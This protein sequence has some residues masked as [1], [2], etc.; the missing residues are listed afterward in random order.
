V[1][2]DRATHAVLVRRLDTGEE[3]LETYDQLVL[4]PGAKAIVPDV[5][6]ADD[7]RVHVIRTVEDTLALR[8]CVERDQPQQAVVVGG[9]FIGLEAA[10]NLMGLGMQVTLLQRGSHVL[11]PLDD[12]MARLV[13]A[14][15]RDHGLDLR[16]GAQLEGF[17][18]DGRG[19]LLVRVAGDGPLSADLVVMAVG[20]SPDT[21][22]AQQAGLDMGVKGSIVVDAHMR[23]S[24]PDIHAVGDAVQ[25]CDRVTGEP[26][27]V[28]LAGPANKQGR[29]AADDIC[30]REGV[31]G[32]TQGSFVLKLF[33]LTVAGSGL[34]LAQARRAGFDAERVVTFSPSHAT[35][36]PGATDMTLKTVF[37]RATGRVLG[38]QAVGF[39][40]VDKRMDVLAVAVRSGLTVDDLTELELC[41]APPFSSAK[42]PVNMAGFVAQN[43]RDGLVAQHH[44]DELPAILADPAARLLDVRTEG[45]FARGHI[46]GAMNIPVDDLRERMDELD[47]DATWYVNCQSA[48]R[49]YIACRILAQEGFRCSNLSGGYRFLEQM[50][51]EDGFDAAPAHPCGISIA[52]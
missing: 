33:D 7:P 2:I 14:Y 34:N 13:H 18:D 24:D 23:T 15:L 21:A 28:P 30:G 37:D 48:L 29:I 39:E 9:G 50:V 36:Y 35:Y 4:A 19:G 10:E 12:D 47:P 52:I 44:W 51:R 27:V 45:E 49:S 5:P 26:T 8:E 32:G 11:P 40:G 25:V 31:Y 1:A 16:T 42:D 3:Y 46:A 22:I 20:V 38:A 41:Y 43:V 17:E 6:G